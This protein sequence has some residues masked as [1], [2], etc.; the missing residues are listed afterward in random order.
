MF[1]FYTIV[2]ISQADIF[3]TAKYFLRGKMNIYA[4]NMQNLLSLCF[5]LWYKR[6]FSVNIFLRFQLLAPPE[7]RLWCF[8]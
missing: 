2:A 8:A 7:S 6:F 4:E 1:E 5:L 3:P